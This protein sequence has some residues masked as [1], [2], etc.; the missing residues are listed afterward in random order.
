[1][2]YL[3]NQRLSFRGRFFSDVS[4]NN[5]TS[6]NFR[7]GAEQST[8]WNTL[9][10]SAV[11][12]LECNALVAGAV[13]F[14]DPAKDFVIT[15]AIDRSSGKM[16]DLDPQWQMSSQLWG[17]SLRVADRHTGE[18]ALE[19]RLAVC[20][21][22]DLWTR[23]ESA[24][25]N[26]QAAGGRFV[27]VLEDLTWGA[28]AAQSPALQALRSETEGNRLSVGMHTFGYFYNHQH[29]RYRTGSIMLHLGP[30]Y[31]GEPATALVHRR[32]QGITVEQRD[33]GGEFNVIDDI[34][35]ALSGNGQR[36]HLDIGH[37]LR[38]A[39]PNGWLLDYRYMPEPANAIAALHVG[40][41][42]PPGTEIESDTAVLFAQIP[43]TDAEWYR[44]SGGVLSV[45]IP[46]EHAAA[47][48]NTPFAIFA[49]LPDG[50]LLL[51]SSETEDGVF[52]RTDNFVCRLETGA[53]TEVTIHARQFGRP[54][55]G[56]Q[57]QIVLNPSPITG[58]LPTLSTP[59]PTNE[60]G[61]TVTQ[62]TG[63]DPGE[64]RADLGLDGAIFSFSYG[65]KVDAS[66][67]ID[68][69]GTGLARLDVIV[70]HARDPYPVP[71]VPNFAEHIEPIMTQYAQLY[72]IMSE[73]LFDLSDYDALVVNRR[74]LLLAFERSIEDPN[75][76]PVTRDLSEGRLATIVKW[77]A[78]VTE[79]VNEPL[80][81][82]SRSSRAM[83]TPPSNAPTQS[84]TAA[85]PSDKKSEAAQAM[86]GA[87]TRTVIPA[88]V[89]QEAPDAQN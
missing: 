52:Y 63:V 62:L 51:L 85:E 29:P 7:V 14:D 31:D 54:L 38:L 70:V 37:A 71:D 3:A 2:S 73:H 49:E 81:R 60:R 21:F 27:S 86:S 48:E 5:N 8:L 9:G 88:S 89:F 15:G 67:A 4:T 20:A 50:R 66:G 65:H 83:S 11:E 47:A 79:D 72:P 58:P 1:M 56:L 30:W 74:A 64:P 26:G 57:F 69:S 13:E 55:E 44:R 46:S 32:L 42:P 35:F 33:D 68:K 84:N 22:R 36:L 12:L 41:L 23:Q 87:A 82:N 16:V 59:P 19:G 24:A 17:M 61:I 43:V 75:Y 53:T 10:G 40:L 28:A 80:L 78:T 76:M 25:L 39:D 34:D 45:A 6:E 18:L 77:L